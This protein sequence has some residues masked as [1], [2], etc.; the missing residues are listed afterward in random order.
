M[1]TKMQQLQGRIRVYSTRYGTDVI[2]RFICGLRCLHVANICNRSGDS[3][4]ENNQDSERATRKS[5]ADKVEQRSECCR[6]ERTQL[7]RQ[8]RILQVDNEVDQVDVIRM[9]GEIKGKA[10]GA[11]TE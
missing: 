9:G 5:D 6:S 1:F 3:G 10:E 7:R 8:W 4:D 11:D 2:C